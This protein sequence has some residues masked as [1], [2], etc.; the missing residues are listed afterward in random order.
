MKI[1][2]ARF[3]S[4]FSAPLLVL[5]LALSGTQFGC[6]SSSKKDKKPATT[7]KFHL[8]TNPDSTER[9]IVATV[10]RS[11]PFEVVVQDQAF[12]SEIFIMEA[13]VVEVVG[14]FQI[15]L[16]FDRQGRW[17]LEQNTTPF[18]GRHIAI[19]SEFGQARWLGAPVITQ[20]IADGVF[21]FTPDATRA[22]TDR[23]VQGLQSIANEVRK[24]ERFN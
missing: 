22:E 23:I 2:A 6:K 21:R 14:G 5:I 15:A 19:Y 24:D 9:H 10:G 8:E 12:L 3:N 1:T 13:N 11:S 7:M 20:G 17:I 4:Y 16:K 18:K